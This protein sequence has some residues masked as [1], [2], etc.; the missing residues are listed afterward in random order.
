M[1]LQKLWVSRNFS[2]ISRVSQSQFLGVIWVSQ[3]R[4]LI[5]R[6]LGVREFFC[7]IKG[8]NLFV[9]FV[10][11]C[12][13]VSWYWISLKQLSI[14]EEKSILTSPIKLSEFHKKLE[15][16]LQRHFVIRKNSYFV[17]DL[18]PKNLFFSIDF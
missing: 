4:F 2:R 12:L 7:K 9:C 14:S 15:N 10:K 11:W 5:W 18:K 16:L 8:P 13:L 6:C 1:V 3:S 17:L